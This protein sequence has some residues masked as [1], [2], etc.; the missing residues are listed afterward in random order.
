MQKL[1][2]IFN[3]ASGKM[4]NV[5]GDDT[6]VKSDVITTFPR[7]GGSLITVEEIKGLTQTALS[8][9]ASNVFYIEKPSVVSPLDGAGSFYGYITTS[10][11]KTNNNFIGEHTGTDWMFTTT[12]DFSEPELYENMPHSLTSYFFTPK[13]VNTK[14]YLKV[15]Y[16]SG[17]AIVTGK[18]I[19][20]AHV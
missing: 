7:S 13:V 16:R 6:A 11:F 20:R 18:Q 9:L 4:T 17:D 1:L 19:G 12:K 15:R 3:I 10:A 8:K 14:Y 2:S 5:T